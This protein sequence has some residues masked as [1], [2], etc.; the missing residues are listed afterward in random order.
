MLKLQLKQLKPFLNVTHF[1]LYRFHLRIRNEFTINM[2]FKFTI[3]MYD[4][5]MFFTQWEYNVNLFTFN[6]IYNFSNVLWGNVVYRTAFINIKPT[7]IV[8][9]QLGNFIYKV[10]FKTINNVT[11]SMVSLWWNNIS[12]ISK[13]GIIKLLKGNKKVHAGFYVLNILLIIIKRKTTYIP[14]IHVHPQLTQPKSDYNKNKT[15][16]C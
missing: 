6:Y 1:N 14:Q 9:I 8:L 3:K 10:R 11:L 4:V 2:Q 16:S 15:L 13:M 5:D 12:K 7:H